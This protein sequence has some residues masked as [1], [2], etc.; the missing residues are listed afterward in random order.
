[1]KKTE[2]KC[3]FRFMKCNDKCALRVKTKTY[4]HETDTTAIGHT[5]SFA[6]MAS[7]IVGPVHAAQFVDE[8]KITLPEDYYPSVSNNHAEEEKYQAF[9][10]DSSEEI[11]CK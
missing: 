9:V 6:A 4:D 8:P 2:A 5:C 3:P 7:N 10:A 1:M 11:P